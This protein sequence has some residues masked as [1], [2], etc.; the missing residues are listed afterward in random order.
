MWTTW[1]KDERN[2]D[3]YRLVSQSGSIPNSCSRRSNSCRL[4]ANADYRL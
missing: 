4:T 2:D 3:E 1:L